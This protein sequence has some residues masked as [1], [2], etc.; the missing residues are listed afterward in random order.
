MNFNA[1]LIDERKVQQIYEQ[2]LELAK[3]YCPEWSNVK[4]STQDPD[5]LGI[6]L[7]KLFSKLT[8]TVIGQVNRIPEKHLLAFYDFIGIDHMPPAAANVPLTFKL[9]EGSKQAFVPVRTKVASSE[10]PTVIFET[11][12][13]LTA[14]NFKIKAA[15][16]VNP[17]EDKYTEHS[18]NTDPSLE[19][20]YIFGGYKNEKPVEHI[21]YISDD[22]FDFKSPADLTIRFEFENSSKNY[23]D[24]FSRCFNAERE[25]LSQATD[26][27]FSFVKFNDLILP[28]KLIE[29]KEANWILFIP[30]DNLPITG[31][32]D[33]P[34]ITNITCDVTAN[35]IIPDSAFFNN[36]PIDVKKG[37]YPFGETPKVGD[38][39]Y[40]ACDDAF[41]KM[42]YTNINESELTNELSLTFDVENPGTSS[43]LTLVWEYWDGKKWN[44]I[45]PEDTSLDFTKKGKYTMKF[46]PQSK[47][48]KT[49]LNGISSRWVRVRI[50]KGSYGDPLKVDIEPSDELLTKLDLPQEILN[51]VT[52]AFKNRN[53]TTLIKYRTQTLSPPFIKEL[54]IQYKVNNKEIT[55]I[56]TFN[57]YIG[58]KTID[59]ETEKNYKPFTPIEDN[60]LAF[61][62]GYKDNPSNKPVN[63]YFSFDTIPH[64]RKEPEI[65]NTNAAGI[66]ST[67]ELQGFIW[68]YSKSD[69]WSELNVTDGTDFFT[70]NGII[71]FICPSDIEKRKLI[72]KELYWLR[73]ES[74]NEQLLRP[75]KLRGIFSNTVWAEN[76]AIVKDE[77]LGSSNGQPN[78][79]FTFSS[80]PLLEK[81]TIEIK[82]AGKPSE[83]ELKDFE[84]EE[85]ADAVRLLRNDSGDV[86]EVWVRWQEVKTFVLSKPLSRHYI[87]DRVNGK[88]I[89]G[90]GVNGMI[91]PALPNNIVAKKYK[92]GGGRKG[93]KKVET[94]KGLQT[95]IPNIDSVTNRDSASGGKDL[96]L[97]KNI[98]ER[99]PYSIKNSGRGVTTE[100]F[101]WL[102][103]EAS[104]EVAKTRCIK[105]QK[106]IKIIIAPNYEDGSLYPQASLIDCV[107]T[108][109]KERAFAPI[110][111]DIMVLGPEYKN[112]DIETK[113][114]TVSIT[115]SAIV[116]YRVERRLKEFLN[117]ITGGKYFQGWEFGQDIYL[118]EIAAI[119]EDVESV[120]Y[121]KELK[122]NS[123]DISQ[124]SV[125]SI[126]DNEL[127]CAGLITVKSEVRSNADTTAGFR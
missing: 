70:K 53:I 81:Q 45:N 79:V 100:D 121:I 32:S 75:P 24:Y 77:L 83:D 63:L 41:S 36:T 95:T 23:S 90:D 27:V 88:L 82:E 35:N 48:P 14:V 33:L 104:A 124:I 1:P 12:E 109:L 43:D 103:K 31:I 49:E 19:G 13:P 56:K 78:Q 3:K 102:A 114:V 28:K 47:I 119:I 99:A 55:T 84:P 6:V 7:L 120:D 52:T 18:I 110:K 91:P 85:R 44:E 39:F 54:S 111:S 89:F 98:L 40:I 93:N 126:E 73:I 127:P 29:D 34:E 4:G 60:A 68:K 125:I 16:S 74:K 97:I 67:T 10:D 108:Y 123:K 8:E 80:K 106:D 21:L 115:E 107:E 122:I 86:Q 11:L 113:I 57:T 62:I 38:A 94:I 64:D 59:F 15:F 51:K 66:P 71:N 76:A 50:A 25:S 42:G 65:K 96:E 92:S 58:F 9:S 26:N 22:F 118:S 117:P 30:R 2:A 72:G 69:K 116:A 20:F 46:K 87:V 37:F 112:I 5:D 105:E 61:L 101:E 17:S